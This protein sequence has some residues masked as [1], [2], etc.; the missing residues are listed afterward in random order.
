MFDFAMKIAPAAR[1]RFTTNA[2]LPVFIPC[3]ERDP[4]VVSMS[5]VS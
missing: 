1:R 3:S 2:S 5:A 4:A